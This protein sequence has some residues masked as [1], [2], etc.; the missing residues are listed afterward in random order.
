MSEQEPILEHGPWQEDPPPEL[1]LRALLQR[2]RQTPPDDYFDTFWT[3]LS[4]RLHSTVPPQPWVLR[5]L[6]LLKS[7]PALSVAAAVLVVA[8][9]LPQ[10]LFSQNPPQKSAEF[11]VQS[12]SNLDTSRAKA[13]PQGGRVV[14]RNEQARRD[15]LLDE[16]LPLS[17]QDK[18]Q[19]QKSMV[20]GAAGPT[21]SAEPDNR[22]AAPTD[23]YEQTA[24]APLAQTPIPVLQGYNQAD[25]L[26]RSAAL[27]VEVQKLVQAFAQVSQVIT[28]Q[29]GYIVSSEM[30]RPE[31]RTAWARLSLKVPRQKFLPALSALE[32]MGE[33][34]S[35][36]IR[37][38]DLWLQVQRQQMTEADL[39][40]R[41]AS[42]LPGEQR[43]LKQQLH[44]QK[45]QRLQF[46]QMLRM[47]SIELQLT[48]KAAVRFWQMEGIG[49]QLRMR[50]NQALHDTLRL[51]VNIIVVLPP[52]FIYFGCA[53]LVWRLLQTVL[54]THLALLSTRALGMAYLLALLFFPLALGGRDLFRATLL[55]VA[56]L[57]GAAGIRLLLQRW[58]R[59]ESLD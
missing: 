14:A 25:Y 15:L 28:A 42:A 33:V 54:V 30:S 6:H 19:P 43:A 37:S 27:T 21:A 3:E 10:G 58:K 12:P 46:E 9:L 26:V 35:K 36:Q 53:W 16:Q 31:Q 20:L 22:P 50:L 32:G 24:V 39:R 1:E 57:T 8:L 51:L 59:D 18:S 44:E 45:I 48:Q 56:L 55:F 52:L 40:E 34:R 2:I 49:E 41:L 23:R 17:E 38:E 13:L 11:S 4:P 5:L 7:P 29:G 47:A